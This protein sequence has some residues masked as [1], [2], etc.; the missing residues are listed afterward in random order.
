MRDVRG[1]DVYLHGCVCACVRVRLLCLEHIDVGGNG[2]HVVETGG[3][4]SPFRFVLL[5]EWTLRAWSLLM[6]AWLLFSEEDG[7][8]EAVK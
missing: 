8:S 2:L 4:R 7:P 3:H 5:K 1:G 6:C